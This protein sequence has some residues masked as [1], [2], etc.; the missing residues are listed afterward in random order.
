MQ[1]VSDSTGQ[2]GEEE[3]ST[4]QATKPILEKRHKIEGIL[5]RDYPE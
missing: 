4:S 2:F 1:F 5:S 3:N